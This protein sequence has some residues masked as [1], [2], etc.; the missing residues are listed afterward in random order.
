LKYG[1]NCVGEDGGCGGDGGEAD[2]GSV[3][4]FTILGGEEFVT[5]SPLILVRTSALLF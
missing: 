1:S 4:I 3:L 5:G 2:P